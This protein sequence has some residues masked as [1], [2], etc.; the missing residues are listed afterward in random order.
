METHNFIN[1]ELS[2]IE[3][4]RR[5]F[6]EAQREDLPLM[7]RIKFLAI[8]HSNFDEFYMVRI[9]NLIH[10]VEWG[11]QISCP[12]GKKPSEILDAV[13]EKMSKIIKKQH[14]CFLEDLYP[15]LKELEILDIFPQKNN[16]NPCEILYKEEIEPLLTPLSCDPKIFDRNLI[17]GQEIHLLLRLKSGQK[18]RD[19]VIPLPTNL[20]RFFRPQDQGAFLPLETI[21]FNHIALLFPQEELQDKALFR[22]LRDADLTV[23]E[24]RDENFLKAMEEVLENR[25][26]SRPMI[27]EYSQ[28]SPELLTQLQQ[29][30]N[31]PKQRCFEHSG[32]LQMKD[33]F[34]LLSHPLSLELMLPEQKPQTSPYLLDNKPPWKK[35]LERDILL[36]H[37]Y[38]SF[39]PVVQLI[40]AAAED[41]RVMAIKMTLYRTSTDSPV[42]LALLEAAK[43]GK[44]V[45]VLVELKARFDEN[46]N[47]RGAKKLTRAGAL[48][49]FGVAGLKVHAKALLILR[50]E[51]EGFKRY[52]HMSTGN[53]NDI[54]AK[55]YTDFSLLT[56]REDLTL[57]AA[58]FFNALTG[59]SDPPELHKLAMAPF[60]LKSQVISLLE[61]EISRAQEGEEARFIGKFN[62]ITDPEM[63]EMMYK[64]SQAGVKVELNIRGIC[65]VIPGVEGLSE[66]IRIISVIGRYLE[67]SRCYYFLNGGQ[68]EIYLSSA[69]WMPR[70][71]E[72]RVELLFPL[73][74]PEHREQV[75]HILEYTMADNC[76]AHQLKKSGRWIRLK[77]GKAG[78]FNSQEY[79]YEYYQNRSIE[80]RQEKQETLKVRKT[81]L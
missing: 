37:P 71:L 67:H 33:F 18:T 80:A 79:L 55:I 21:L 23:D 74:D 26:D 6:S 42:I 24:Q 13:L 38:E 31:L 57:E 49:I 32:I 3:F 39:I 27:L 77:P 52:L 43:A 56:T 4:N 47:I 9:A 46:R 19:L 5:V 59:H 75:K 1:R 62:S 68:E 34:Q 78:S 36:H 28:C 44:Q 58:Q 7:E 16:P 12:S 41:P 45:T 10:E 35:L 29:L 69:D 60:S 76:Q 63:V 70:N 54:T 72:R 51:K 8:V 66:N 25:K 15:K 30:L 64:A 61:R 48:V 73:L 20:P 53:Y 17:K 40:Q 50:K 11:N 81:P 2:W 65:S 22:I 14:R